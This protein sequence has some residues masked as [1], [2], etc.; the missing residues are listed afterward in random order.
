VLRFF[1]VYPATSN[2]TLIPPIAVVRKVW[3]L[4]LLVHDRA[5]TT[6]SPLRGMDVRH[7]G[8]EVGRLP[9]LR[10]QGRLLLISLPRQAAADGCDHAMGDDPSSITSTSSPG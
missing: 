8:I 1:Q 9:S 4:L 3:S 5:I 10:L 2:G 6:L 7:Q